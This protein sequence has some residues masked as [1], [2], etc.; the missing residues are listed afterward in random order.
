MPNQPTPLPHKIQLNQQKIR[1]TRYGIVFILLL[2]G[3]LAGSINYN[4]NL[5]FLITFLLGSIAFASIA[6]TFKN[7]SGIHILSCD[8][9]PVFV[10]EQAVFEFVADDLQTYRTGIRFQ[11]RDG[12]PVSLDLPKNVKN[13]IGVAID[14][15]SRGLLRPWPLMIFSDYPLGLFRVQSSLELNRA[16]VVYPKPKIGEVKTSTGTSDA[17]SD[18][19]LRGTGTDDFQGLRA[20]VPGD[21]LQRISWKASSRG[22]GLFTKDFNG[23]HRASFFLDWQML[24]DLDTEDRLSLLCHAVLTA[25]QQNLTYGLK[26]PG[27]TIPPG[28]GQSHKNR[29]LKTL[30]LF[31]DSPVSISLI[32]TTGS[33]TGPEGEIL[34]LE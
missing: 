20:Y 21:P 6:H 30:A 25:Q 7:I 9:Q 12:Q 8:T 29:C 17:E 11:F 28:N 26:L 32:P 5:A 19:G 27:L 4:N 23:Y 16:C 1:P 2:L 22:R 18:V 10:D 3:M 24:P 34:R 13:R 14:A 31:D 15:T 33:T